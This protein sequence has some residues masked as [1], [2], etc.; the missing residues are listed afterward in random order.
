MARII[1]ETFKSFIEDATKRVIYTPIHEKFI[2]VRLPLDT[3]FK[4]DEF[5]TVTIE[6]CERR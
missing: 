3:K 1:K 6:T 2:F 5:V 4:Q